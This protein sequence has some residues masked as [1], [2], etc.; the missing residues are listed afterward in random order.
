MLILMIAL[1][2]LAAL[3]GMYLLAY[4]LQGKET[5]KALVFIHGP[6]A[7]T[8]LILLVIYAYWYSPPMFISAIILIL[9]ALGGLV[10]IYRDLTGKSVPAWLG[11]AHGITAIVG[12]V[13]LLMF[14]IL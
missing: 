11:L 8:A 2:A 9:A 4:I 10:L 13:V 14:A 12:F 5:P 1:F 6:V 7:A 3:I